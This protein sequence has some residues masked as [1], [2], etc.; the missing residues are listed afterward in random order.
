INYLDTADLYDFG[1]NEEIVG[2]AIKSRRQDVI[3]ATKAG[4]RWEEGK[5]GWFWDPRKAYIKEAVKRSLKRLQ[6]DYIDLYQLHG[7]TIEDNI[8]ETIEA[9]EE[10][11]QEGVIRHYGISSI[12]PNVLKEYV[13]KSNIVTVM[14]QYSLL[15]RRPEEWLSLLEEHGIS[16]IARGPLAKGILTEKPLSDANA[17]IKKSG[18]LS[19][20]YDELI[21]TKAD[22]EKAAPDLSATETALKYILA[23]PAVGAV[24]P[25]ASKLSQLRENVES[26][27]G[28]SLTEQEIKAL[29]FY[30]KRDVYTA[31]RE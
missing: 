26:V 2:E 24:I 5:P 31:H 29:R 25:G 11:K 28:R 21:K 22:I 12:R 6:T 16:V 3:L 7:G 1:R 8:D 20:S 10:L 14:M 17:S 15:D 4:N 23:Q 27:G 30:T 13:K 9:F 18:Y 19:Y